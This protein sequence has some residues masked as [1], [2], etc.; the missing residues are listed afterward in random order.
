MPP[1]EAAPAFGVFLP[2]ASGGWIVSETAPR[3]D[4]LWPQNLAAARAAEA[5]GL[6]FIMSMAKW[7]GFGGVTDF[8]G[9]SLESMTL[10]AALAQATHRIKLWATAH[11]RLFNPAV[12]AKMIATIDHISGGRAGLNIASGAYRE[13]FAQMGAWRADL[14]HDARYDEVEAWTRAVKRLWTEPRVTSDEAGLGLEDCTSAPKPLSRPD[15]ISPGMSRRGLAFAVRE[16]DICFIGGRTEEERRD[17]SR[18]AHD[19]AAD[20]GRRTRTFMMCTVIHAESDA[21]AEREV[22]RLAAG[23]DMGAIIAMLQSWGAPPERLTEL[24]KAQGPFMTRTVVG[25]PA[26]CAERIA[27]FMG[28]CELDGLMLIFP[29]YAE[30]VPMFGRE[31]LPR[32]RSVLAG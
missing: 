15:L 9:V 5:A 12:A 2:V 24:A 1:A 18:M 16:A 31:I 19:M 8:W 21:A 11:P 30:G 10:T 7:R 3:L 25:S 26:T 29:D 32:L 14:D 4:G 6:D 27:Q 28:A 20:L 23:A 13:E 17:T 22:A